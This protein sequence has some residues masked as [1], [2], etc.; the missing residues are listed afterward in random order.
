MLPNRGGVSFP[1]Q[2]F[3]TAKRVN[4]YNKSDILVS[5][6]RPYFKKIW[7]AN[8]GGTRS[9]DI[10][11]FRSKDKSRLSQEYLYMILQSDAFFDYVTKTSKGTKMP[12]GDKKAIMNFKIDLPPIDEQ[13]KKAESVLTIER[14]IKLN[15]QINANLV[16]LIDIIYNNFCSNFSS[17]THQTISDVFNVK[18]TTYS[19]KE[20]K[21]KKVLHFSI[22]NFDNSKQA[23]YENTSN[24]KSN[25]IIV[26]P[27]SVLI[28][29]LNPKF[30]RIWAPNIKSVK[31]NISVASP[32]FL[33]IS[34]SNL[35]EQ[36]IIFAIVN[37]K[38]Y[39]EFLISNA[40]GS[41]NSRQRVKP[42]T[43]TSYVIPFNIK[44][45]DQLGIA[46]QP[47]LQQIQEN[48]VENISLQN[49]KIN[50]LEYLF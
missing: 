5:N 1:A 43:A 16:D 19:I 45:M 15:R 32:E 41:T 3:T 50:L 34:G 36:S 18:S 22:P 35:E 9:G 46:L 11:T 33:Q 7:F 28:S 42:V 25:K 23:Q 29:K 49:I 47:L 13:L 40:T 24:I 20:N 6:I 4:I 37:S 26:N 31:N 14:K 48:E 2:S 39:Y 12:R 27:F 38:K 17:E 30:Q 44:K 10:L 8:H 21:D